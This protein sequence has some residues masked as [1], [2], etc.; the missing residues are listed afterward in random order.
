MSLFP[1][2]M[3][4][5]KIVATTTYTSTALINSTASVYTFSDQG[6][7]TAFTGR[8]ICV[9]IY[10]EAQAHQVTALTVGGIAGTK[11]LGKVYHFDWDSL[12]R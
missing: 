10:A 9:G 3:P 6:I 11:I 2:F 7:G 5:K 12:K 8:K 1:I 4:D